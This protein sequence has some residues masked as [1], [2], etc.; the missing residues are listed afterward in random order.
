MRILLCPSSVGKRHGTNFLFK[1]YEY[2]RFFRLAAN[3]L[4][5]EFLIVLTVIVVRF[6]LDS[7][8]FLKDGFKTRNVILDIG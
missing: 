6:I 4:F 8:W 5:L 7:E 1:F 3:L 2:I